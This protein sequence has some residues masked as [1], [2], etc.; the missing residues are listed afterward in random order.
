MAPIAIRVL[1]LVALLATGSALVAVGERPAEARAGGGIET[2][3]DSDARVLRWSDLAPV[4]AN[5][6]VMQTQLMDPF[7]AASGTMETADRHAP[8]PE[9]SGQRVSIAGYMTPLLVDGG[10]TQ[11]FL[12]VPYVGACVH[13]PAPPPNQIVL[14]E[15]DEPIDVLE[16]WEP[17]S[18][19]G[20]LYV[21]N[22]DTDLAEVGYT[23]T[24]DRIAPYRAEHGALEGVRSANDGD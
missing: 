19:V 14:V 18:A 4:E 3:G 6:L 11:A 22:V 24:L 8:R 2:A 21:Q 17:F 15:S 16:M 5:D 10:T 23:M 13:V 12:L 7:E 9:L 20:T 1:M